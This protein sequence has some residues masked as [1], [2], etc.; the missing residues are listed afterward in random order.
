MT[1]GI[2]AH[3]GTRSQHRP[4]YA[5]HVSGGMHRVPNADGIRFC[6]CPSVAAQI[7]IVAPA[8]E[9]CPGGR[10]DRDVAVAATEI[11]ESADPA[12]GITVAGDVSGE[13]V[14]A[15]GSVARPGGVACECILATVN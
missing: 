1:T 12:G 11:V 13:R 6:R 10:A 5:R 7:N 8:G 9:G 15:D 2:N 3:C 4:V 14:V